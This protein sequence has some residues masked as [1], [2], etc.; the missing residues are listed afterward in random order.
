MRVGPVGEAACHSTDGV[1]RRRF[2][3]GGIAGLGC[4]ALPMPSLA[5]TMPMNR[6]FAI[7]REGDEIGRHHVRFTPADNGFRARTEIEI[8]VKVAFFTAFQFRQTADDLWI[9]GQLRESRAS[10][11][12]NGD[13]SETFIRATGNGLAVEGGEANRAIQ[14]PLGTMTDLAFWNV[15]I[16][17]QQA[18]VDTQKVKLTD[19]AA[20]PLGIETVEGPH[21]PV[22]AE[23]F[24]CAA[25][26]GRSGDIWFD[27]DGNWVKGIMSVRGETLAYRLI[28]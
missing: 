10:T 26:T 17:R 21:G 7:F 9:D 4:L 11:D 18:L 22:T 27:S 20:K 16:V 1:N 2:L 19:L 24:T 5:A 12:D 13:V 15:A 8:E 28:A 6:T 23:R 3:V 14:V 25:T